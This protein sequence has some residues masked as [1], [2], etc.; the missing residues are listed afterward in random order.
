ML[1]IARRETGRGSGS[2]KDPM[3]AARPEVTAYF[4]RQGGAYESKRICKEVGS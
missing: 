4:V 1:H 2:D 3:C